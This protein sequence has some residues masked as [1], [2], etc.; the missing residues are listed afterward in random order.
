MPSYNLSFVWED[1]L[2][3]TAQLDF[4]SISFPFSSLFFLYFTLLCTVIPPAAPRKVSLQPLS[5]AATGTCELRGWAELRQKWFYQRFAAALLARSRLPPSAT[6]P[7]FPE[8]LQPE[9]SSCEKLK[10]K[11]ENIQYVC[12]DLPHICSSSSADKLCLWDIDRLTCLR[13]LELANPR[14]GTRDR[15]RERERD[16]RLGFG[17]SISARKCSA[18]NV[19]VSGEETAT[20]DYMTSWQL[21]DEH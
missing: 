14:R 3:L 15:P 19:E 6:I 17:E 2:A 16:R 11:R 5:V 10:Q 8:P 4:A 20:Q 21:R 1:Y 7:P 9:P 12:S 18:T 13:M